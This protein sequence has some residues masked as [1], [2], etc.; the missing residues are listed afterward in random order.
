MFIF[1]SKGFTI[2]AVDQC[3]SVSVWLSFSRLGRRSP[4]EGL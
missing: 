3:T 1:T 4:S 2:E